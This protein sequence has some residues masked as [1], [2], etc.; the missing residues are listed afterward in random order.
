MADLR[1]QLI[2]DLANK[3]SAPLK[4]ISRG[5]SEAAQAI[6]QTRE[7]MRALDKQQADITGYRQSTIEVRRKAR[8]LQA[9]QERVNRATQALEQQRNAT[10][11][12]T[13]AIQRNEAALRRARQALADTTRHHQLAQER[14]EGYKR[15]LDEAGHSTERLGQR[16]KDLT[17]QQ[18]ELNQ[19][20]DAQRRKLAEVAAHQRKLDD[21]RNRHTQ[22]MTRVGMMAGLGVAGV[23]AGRGMAAPVT[24]GLGAFA[25]QETASAQLR[26]SMM[27]AG[28]GVAAEFTA[29]NEL[30]NRLG[31]KL[32]GTT[33]DF[34]NM[35]TMLRRQGLSAQN[36]LGGTGE[37]AAYLGVQLRMPVTEAAEFAAKMQD[38]TQTT[39]GDMMRLMD[40][41]QRTYYLGV[42]SGN[43]LQGFTKVGAA[44]SIIHQQGLQAATTLAPLLVMMDQ[45]GMSGEPAG[46]ALRKVFQ[47]S[48]DE[49]K[50]GKANELLGSMGAGF[51]LNFSD[52]SGK[53]AGLENLYAQLDKIKGIQSDTKRIGLLKTLFGDDAETH[54]VLGVMMDKGLAG[55]REVAAKMQ[56]QADLRTRVDD[57]LKTLA[58]VREAAA[59]TFTNVLAAL[60]GTMQGDAKALIEWLGSA[61]AA[62]RGWIEAHPVL[63][64]WLMRLTA[65]LA[66]VT[67]G[68]GA[69]M[70]GIASIAGPFIMGRFALGLLQLSGLGPLVAGAITSMTTA[71]LGFV[72]ANLPLIATLALLA[73]SAYMVYSNWDG[74]KGGAIALWSD[75]TLAATNGMEFLFTLP[76]R[77]MQAGA[78]LMRGLVNG[79]TGQ[80]SSVQ[81]AIGGVADSTIGWFREKLGIRSPSR[82][83]EWAGSQIPLGAAQGVRTTTPALLGAISAMSIAASPLAAQGQPLRL[84]NRPPLAASAGTAAGSA[85][86]GGAI[87]IN[88]YPQPGQDPQAIAR[89]V[90]A[91]LD[92]RDRQRA[93][94]RASAYI[95]N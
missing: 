80:L 87:T 86:G 93:S 74:I 60:G 56:A 25:E 27:Q 50:L 66:L 84:D 45:A 43:M 90:A 28:G 61:A 4:A 77:A 47:L 73:G 37:A 22:A 72:A 54:Q 12:D 68:M 3:A 49:K 34:I 88:I 32:P 36:I 48:L 46:N 82:V 2:L 83:F 7:Q 44:M 13:A 20:L 10:Q 89:A 79:I 69:L 1:L 51:K 52:K 55:Y 8:E 59:G 75:I 5:S 94:R 14:A 64:G 70:V 15:R 35:M 76:N 81:A 39:E 24:A 53:F 41:I 26:A 95:D 31:D 67:A 65:G 6:K 63:V 16:S 33:A 21:L 62:T 18:K 42:D 40:L 29:I 92:K 9:M 58:N 85:A 23:A 30:A 57:Q 17:R 38:A 91:E 71:S 19:T 11:Q 78:N